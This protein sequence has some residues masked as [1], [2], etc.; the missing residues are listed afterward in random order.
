MTTAVDKKE[1]ESRPKCEKGTVINAHAQVQ[2]MTYRHGDEGSD[3]ID[4]GK[5]CDLSDKVCD[6]DRIYWFIGLLR[7]L[8]EK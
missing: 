5:H 3:L 2:G 8:T 6:A 4:V 7:S 1:V